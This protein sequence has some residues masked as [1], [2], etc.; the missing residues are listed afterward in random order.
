MTTLPRIDIASGRSAK[1][2]RTLRAPCTVL[3]GSSSACDLRI[4]GRGVR[5]HHLA[6]EWDGERLLILGAEDSGPVQV[7]GRAVLLPFPIVGSMRLRIGDAELQATAPRPLQDDLTLVMADR[8]ATEVP[9]PVAPLDATTTRRVRFRRS[10]CEAACAGAGTA[11][12]RLRSAL[13]EGSE[14]VRAAA[15]SAAGGLAVLLVVGL[16]VVTAGF[17]LRR[18]LQPADVLLAPTAARSGDRASAPALELTV[19]RADATESKPSVPPATTGVEP[20]RAAALLVSG[21]RD[22]AAGAY[23]ALAKAHP[24]QPIFGVLARI[25]AREKSRRVEHPGSPPENAP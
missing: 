5:A 16:L 8:D 20:A 18:A 13:E 4:V 6:L 9:P 22:E 21:R 14:R 17:V 12:A 15:G 7:D 3:V 11:K 1:V 24:E 25:L 19:H 10:R 23:A 2:S